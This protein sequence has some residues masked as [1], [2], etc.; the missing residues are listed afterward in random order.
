MFV[1]DKI[2][3]VKLFFFPISSVR[4]NKKVSTEMLYSIWK[5]PIDIVNETYVLTQANSEIL[6]QSKN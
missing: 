3:F 4:K 1:I 2:K 6:F 5:N